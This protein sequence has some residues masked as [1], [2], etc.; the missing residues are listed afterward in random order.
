[1]TSLRSLQRG[2]TLIELSVVAIVMVVLA[3]LAS[4]A[5]VDA[6]HEGMAEATG[7]YLQTLKFAL[8]DYATKNVTEITNNTAVAGFASPLAPTL[9]ELKA[10]GHLTS[11]FPTST[12][13]RQTVTLTLTRS[14]ACPNPGCLISSYVV[15]NSPID[16]TGANIPYLVSIVKTKASGYAIASSDVNPSTLMGPQCE[17]LANPLGAVPYVVGT[18]SVINAGFWAQFVRRGD[19]RLTTLNNSL[20]V[21]GTVTA[22]VA[23]VTGTI[24][25]LTGN[26]GAGTG[27]SGCRLAE[28]L[29]SGAVISRTF[30]CIARAIVDSDAVDGGRVTLM[31]AS[32]QQTV[33][34]K[35]TGGQLTAGTGTATTITIDGQD[36]RITTNGLSPASLPAGWVGGLNAQDVAARGTVGAWDGTNLRATVSANGQ[37][38]ARDPAGTSTAKL[39]GASGRAS[40]RALQATDVGSIGAA[41]ATA[42]DQRQRADAP[43]AYVVCQNGAWVPLGAR[44]VTA[45]SA[46]ATGGEQAVDA[47]GQTMFCKPVGSAGG[48]YFV[49]AKYLMSDFV[50]IASSLVTDGSVVA[51]PTCAVVGSSAGQPLIFVM[52]QTEG[53]SDGAF[54][55]YAVDAG[56]SWT[57]HLKRGDD[58]T[59]LNGASALAMQYCYY[60]SI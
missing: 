11:A 56:S 32:N 46:C 52:G 36:G 53:S 19:D 59:A 29:A 31:N 41:C 24:A 6:M 13:F 12:P 39:D 10:A 15:T 42:G 20:T 17:P 45:G 23:V 58:A 5:M 7:S 37:I 48:G 34:V 21:N 2:F 25:S 26:I 1:M 60:S 40:G 43:G 57:V 49:A 50:F 16:L 35:G 44:V 27:S 4:K 54:N 3:T 8:D 47:T 22:S 9:D 28:L 55:R 30:D 18:C 14:T 51:K 33:Q 38:E